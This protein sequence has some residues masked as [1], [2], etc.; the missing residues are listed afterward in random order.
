MEMPEFD[1]AEYVEPVVIEGYGEPPAS[2]AAFVRA[3][4]LGLVAAVVGCA[5]YAV[6]GFSGFMVSIVAIGVGWVVAKAMMT[7]SG[8]AG[9][10][11]YQIVAV[12]LTYFAVTMGN[13]LDMLHGS[14]IPMRAITRVPDAFLIR[15]ML[16]GPFLSLARS[17]INGGLG[18]LILFFGLRAA[19]QIAAGSPGFGR[20]GR[21]VTPFGLR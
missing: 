13:L 16:M 6:I 8:G 3:L 21:G 2:R 9:G 12:A 18:L 11:A 7:G 17:P 15:E 1:R 19:W 5:A 10:R 20:G 4:A 14:G